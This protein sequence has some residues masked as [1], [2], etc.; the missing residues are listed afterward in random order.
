MSTPSPLAELLHARGLRVTRP[1]LAVLHALC[2]AG[3]PLSHA[4]L[5]ERVEAVQ[6]DRVTL[7]R[8]LDKLVEAGLVRCVSRE[9]G[10]GRFEVA[11]LAEDAG[12][13]HAHFVC[14]DC[15]AVSCLPGEV[16]VQL[17]A[18]ERWG[19]ALAEA[20]VEL[21]GHCPECRAG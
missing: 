13:L 20:Q 6:A 9:G 8:N 7:Y 15:G 17:P 3:R 18:D 19:R 12:H 14:T 16:A 1:R 10:V 11:A 4:E 2:E 5:S 21:K